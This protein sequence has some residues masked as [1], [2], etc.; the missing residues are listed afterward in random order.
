MNIADKLAVQAG[1]N[2]TGL[3]PFNP[4][5]SI[6]M[7]Q[8]TSG[9]PGYDRLLSEAARELFD[10]LRRDDDLHAQAGQPVVVHG[11]SR[12]D[13]PDLS[14]AKR[15]KYIPPAKALLHSLA[16]VASVPLIPVNDA[17]RRQ[18]C[19]A[20]P[21]DRN[22]FGKGREFSSLSYDRFKD[23]VLALTQME[24]LEMVPA[25]YNPETGERKRTRVR[26]AG[27][28]LDWMVQ[29]GVV[30]PYHPQGPY[31]A[32]SLP[33]ADL[34]WISC[35]RPDGKKEKQRLTRPLREEEQVLP[36]LNKALMKQRLAC[37]LANYRQYEA[38]YN[39]SEGRPRSPLGGQKSLYRIFS[40][41]DGRAGRLY[42]H[43]VQRLPQECRGRL[44]INGHPTAELD[45]GGMQLALIYARSGK[46]MPD[47]DDLYAV[48]GFR[49]EEMKA[50]LTRSVGTK[51]RAEALGALRKML[52]EE[53]RFRKGRDTDLYDAFWGFHEGMSPHRGENEA[54]WA[55][56]QALDSRLALRVLG[57]LL[58]QGITAIPIHDSFV[59]EA[60]HADLTA[61]VMRQEFEAL[62]SGGRV[63]VRIC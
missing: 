32:N 36:A 5:D 38:L 35:R 33:E 48:P 27:P 43:W 59:V 50:V 13:T 61:E 18:S 1:A 44:T 4:A 31:K 14:R 19:V 52:L 51:T 9:R 53:G 6:R 41:E 60:R 3:A 55:E 58:D 20:I 11:K 28:L 12:G 45:Y 54:V 34:L 2:P 23:L 24:W 21:L 49:R 26:P 29:K 46:P 39:F 16:H 10:I 8:D 7:M 15:D 40:E 30:F 47:I 42:G 25:H 62:F 56:L 17:L 57:G 22:A 37:P 63:A